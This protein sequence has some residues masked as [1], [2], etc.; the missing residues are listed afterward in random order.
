[1]KKIIAVAALSLAGC[2]ATPPPA[3]TAE[4]AVLNQAQAEAI[5]RAHTNAT[6][7]LRVFAERVKAENAA[8]IEARFV[9]N[10][11]TESRPAAAVLAEVAARDA[12]LRASAAEV[13]AALAKALADDNFAVAEE[14]SAV[15]ADYLAEETERQK[16][17]R[18]F[19]TLLG[20][21]Q[22]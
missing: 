18:R 19:R 2:A 9:A 15:V 17:E 7:S 16:A 6:A 5:R 3:A 21:A 12:A 1:M 8:R 14:I 22:R 10:L 13:D 4:V 11:G 20:V